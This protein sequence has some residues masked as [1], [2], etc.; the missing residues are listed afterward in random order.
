MKKLDLTH[1]AQIVNDTQKLVIQD[2]EP[3]FLGLGRSVTKRK[4]LEYVSY[5][6]LIFTIITIITMI[7]TR[8]RT[9]R[10]NTIDRVETAI[11]NLMNNTNHQ[12][13]RTQVQD[14]TETPGVIPTVTEEHKP[15]ARVMGTNHQEAQWDY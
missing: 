13:P 14:I 3:D 2:V 10:N 4:F 11:R 7:I 5:G 8:C 6:S 9:T 15:K 1:L 12:T